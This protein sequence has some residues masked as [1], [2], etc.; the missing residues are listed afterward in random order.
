MR[1]TYAAKL[2]LHDPKNDNFILSNKRL[3][4]VFPARFHVDDIPSI[5]M[6]NMT[7][8]GKQD[9][10]KNL[11]VERSVS[12]EM[13]AILGKDKASYTGAMS[14]I[15]AYIKKNNLQNEADKK[16]IVP[17]ATLGKLCGGKEIKMHEIPAIIKKNMIH[18]TKAKERSPSSSPSPKRVV[19]RKTRKE[20]QEELEKLAEE[21]AKNR[22]NRLKKF[23]RRKKREER[24]SK[25]VEATS[26]NTKQEEKP[27][28]PTS[29]IR[30]SKKTVEV[31]KI[32]AQTKP[33]QPA[34]E[35]IQEE[36]PKK[37]GG[38]SPKTVQS[39]SVE[40]QKPEQPQ[41][42]KPKPKK[43]AKKETN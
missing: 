7:D 26:T 32:V 21:R 38:R 20:I 12:P 1:L 18:E 34:P 5:V 8:R 37:K 10:P 23:E 36:A 30:P 39:K 19:P 4:E 17:D 6:E 41:A 31:P 24:A 33:K 42:E 25:S 9:V 27:K 16:K 40:P 11:N 14:G 28:T 2:D 35:K 13:S 22:E 43:Q 15:W 29:D 3:A